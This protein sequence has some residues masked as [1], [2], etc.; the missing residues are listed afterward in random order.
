MALVHQIEV[1]S[2]ESVLAGVAKAFGR[3]PPRRPIPAWWGKFEEWYQELTADGDRRP[4]TLRTEPFEYDDGDEEDEEES[5]W[6][7]SPWGGD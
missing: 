6:V 7:G 2:R 1:T 5:G 4:L 3:Y